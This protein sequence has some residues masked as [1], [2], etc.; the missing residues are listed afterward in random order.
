MLIVV[1]GLL[2]VVMGVAYLY[3]NAI[4]ETGVVSIYC[5]MYIWNLCNHLLSKPSVSKTSYHRS[6]LGVGFYHIDYG[7]LSMTLIN[8]YPTLVKNIPKAH[9]LLLNI[10]ASPSPLEEL[11]TQKFKGNKRGYY[12]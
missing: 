10:Q 7:T 8:R 5:Y 9:L 2:G 12:K 6:Y 1:V 11:Y 4:A 3:G